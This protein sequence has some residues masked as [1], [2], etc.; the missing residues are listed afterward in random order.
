MNLRIDKIVRFSGFGVRRVYSLILSDENLYLIRTGNF[1][2]LK[3]YRVDN[4]TQQVMT[5]RPADRS[6]KEIQANEALI[7]STPLDQLIGGDNYLIRLNAIE[8]VAIQAGT[9]PILILK[10]TGSDHRL[11]FPFTPIEQVQTLRRTLLQQDAG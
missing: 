8:D 11:M 7:D 4:L 3:N 10:L 6:V 1:G 9:A 5:D 2:A